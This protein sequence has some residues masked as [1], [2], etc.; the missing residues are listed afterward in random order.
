M[1]DNLKTR[2]YLNLVGRPAVIVPA[3][4]SAMAFVGATFAQN[5]GKP[6]FA[7][8]VGLLVTAGVVGYRFLFMKEEIAEGVRQEMDN[9]QVASH[10]EAQRT[11]DQ[12]LDGL[13]QRLLGDN[14]PRTEE[15]LD[16]LRRLSREFGTDRPWMRAVNSYS[17]SVIR[18]A[19]EK[20][21]ASSVRKLE[22]SLEFYH[23]AREASMRDAREQA[24]ARRSAALEAVDRNIQALE[25]RLSR[26]QGVRVAEDYAPS[27][28]EDLIRQLNDNVDA[29]IQADARVNPNVRAPD[30]VTE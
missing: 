18:D 16:A 13:Y 23:A 22:Q 8:V 29:A 27:D 2:I 4:V 11:R 15:Q 10:A 6:V 30:G 9:E 7:G 17:S 28:D 24:L 1:A 25:E 14:D 26:L 20:I 19:V 3:L 12:E 21:F 5:P